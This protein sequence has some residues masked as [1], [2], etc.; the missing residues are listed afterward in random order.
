MEINFEELVPKDCVSIEGHE[1]N[2]LNKNGNIGNFLRTIKLHSRGIMP[3]LMS[4]LDTIKQ[5]TTIVAD[6]GDFEGKIWNI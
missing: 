3:Q 2:R 6:T 5:Y 1:N 4:A